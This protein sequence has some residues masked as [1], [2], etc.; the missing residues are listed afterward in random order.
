MHKLLC[1]RPRHNH[2]DGFS[3]RRDA[4][5]QRKTPKL[6]H[7]VDEDGEYIESNAP[8]TGKMGRFWSGGG[9][10]DFG[11]YFAPIRRWLEKQV[12][13]PWDKVYADLRTVVNGDS[14]VR[15]HALVHL[16]GWMER[17][18]IERDGKIYQGGGYGRY[19]GT[20]ELPDGA[21]YVHP[22]T[23]LFLRYKRKIKAPKAKDP[24]LLKV[25]NKVFLL[26][27]EGIWYSIEYCR[28][29]GRTDFGEYHPNYRRPGKYFGPKQIGLPVN[30]R[31]DV[32]RSYVIKYDSK[33]KAYHDENPDQLTYKK[34]QLSSKELRKYKLE[35]R[36]Q[37][38]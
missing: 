17:H 27:I 5:E 26:Q 9:T 16:D 32:R 14:A 31:L 2:K 33:G 35:N 8:K 20:W 37:A 3:D 19:I 21:L 23:G 7:G 30:I 36:R 18:C 1:L 28:N 29:V 22:R 6:I 13:R 11:E 24:T 25:S 12:N 10:K 4:Q 34:K 38:A 15:Q